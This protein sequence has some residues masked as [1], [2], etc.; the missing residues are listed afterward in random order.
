MTGIFPSS[1][2]IVLAIAVFVYL[3]FKGIPHIVSTL[4][5]VIIVCIF[6]QN[7]FFPALVD[8]FQSVAS[9]TIANMMLLIFS[10]SALGGIMTATGCSESLG[11][12]FVKWLGVKKAPWIIMLV[13]FFTVLGGNGQYVFVVAAVSISVMSAANMPMY[14]AMVAMS[15]AGVLT[16]FM[17]PGFPGITNIIPTMFLK[18]DV[19]AGGIIGVICFFVGI[20]LHVVYIR[21]LMKQAERD[22]IGYRAPSNIG[23]SIEHTDLPSFGAAILPILSIVILVFVFQKIAGWDANLS[24][25]VAQVLAIIA[26]YIMNWRRI[27]RK[28]APLAASIEKS[29]PFLIGLACIQGFAGVLATTTAYHAV[30]DFVTTINLNPYVTTVLAVACIVGITTDG[31]G[32]MFV[33]FE[34]VAPNIIAKAGV[35]LGVVHRLTTMTATTVDSLPHNGSIFMTLQL[36]G[37]SHKE[38]YKYLFVSSVLIPIVCSAIGSVIGVLFY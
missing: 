18:T 26:M 8:T 4:S 1:I 37:Y 38:G 15:G 16:S 10:G 27:P 30:L 23:P 33:F 25:I 5:A 28:I 9:N 21:R 36:Y 20:I 24:A 17:L 19:Y 35:N 32:G 14:I 34:T 2:G 12:C 6:S 3:I 11:K 31:V 22:H 7:G 13:T 29:L